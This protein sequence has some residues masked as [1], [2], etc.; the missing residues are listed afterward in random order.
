MEFTSMTGMDAVLEQLPLLERPLFGLDPEAPALVHGQF[1]RQFVDLGLAPV[2]L[3][4][5]LDQQAT[6]FVSAELVKVGWQG[7][8]RHDA[9]HNRL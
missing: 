9:G 8:D 5:F 7:H 4:V 2:Q 1:M 3:T 6:Q